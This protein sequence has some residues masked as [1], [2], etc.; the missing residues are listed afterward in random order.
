M[1]FSRRSCLCLLVTLLCLEAG[2]CPLWADDTQDLF[3]KQ[4]FRGE[5]GKAL[6]YRLLPPT[7]IQAGEKYPLVL[8]LHG[9]GERGANNEA[10][11]LHVVQE[12]ARPEMRE[13]HAAFVL[14]PQCPTDEQWVN[15]PW[16]D[17][18][19]V[20]PEQPSES[21]ALT[22]ELQQQLEADLPIDPDR[23]Y[24]TGLSMGGFGVWDLLQRQPQRYAAA[25]AICGGGDL[26]CAPALT[27]IPIWAF[28]GDKDTVVKVH[29][30]QKMVDA[31]RQ[32]GG[33]PIYSEYPGVGHNSWTVTGQNRLV[34]DWLF[35]QAR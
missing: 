7:H 21:L 5:S 4:V 31:I 6:P 34:W 27:E 15:V 11:L 17:D 28:H 10:Q 33:H 29:R 14:A 26:A 16:G 8:F 13:R 23:I 32:A 25:L 3:Q 20:M 19:H 1:E 18:S 9:A 24:L 2:N 12:L 35:A 22:L 30:S